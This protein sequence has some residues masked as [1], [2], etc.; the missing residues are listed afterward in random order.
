MLHIQSVHSLSLAYFVSTCLQSKGAKWREIARSPQQLTLVLM[1]KKRNGLK[2]VHTTIKVHLTSEV[3][4]CIVMSVICMDVCN[5]YLW[6][7][8]YLKVLVS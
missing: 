2:R 7:I 1:E 4:L 6:Q 5:I 3:Q 8:K